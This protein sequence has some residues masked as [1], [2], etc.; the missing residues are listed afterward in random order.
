[1]KDAGEVDRLRRA[2]AIADHALAS[3]MSDLP[4]A[5]TERDIARRLEAVMVG[6]GADE[7][8][9]PT[10]VAAGPNS[11]RPHAVPSERPLSN[12]DLLVV[13][14]GARV[15]GY[16]SDMTRSFVVGSFTA[17]TE[18]IYQRVA[19]AQEAGVAAVRDG[20]AARTVDQVCRE[21]L[22]DAGMGD[23]FIHGTGH[24]IG[25][26]IHE[27]PFLSA[28]ND[29]DLLVAGQV[30]TVEPGVYRS[31][32]GG[33]RIEDSVIVTAD[34]CQPITLSPKDPLLRAF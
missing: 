27:E 24:G 21:L 1:M 8:S 29:D 9:F 28:Q 10:I 22:T 16:G 26:E 20:V 11:A 15:D 7:P 19:E 12:G 5:V 13:D 6:N 32:V 34:G 2:A 33:V 4:P 23:E 30:V 18:E 31:G 25:L 3:V 14:M 17:E